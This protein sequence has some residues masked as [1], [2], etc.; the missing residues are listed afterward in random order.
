M[1]TPIRWLLPLSLTTAMA[2][3]PTSP[4]PGPE[5]T[6][7][8][9]PAADAGSDGGMDEDGGPAD[10]GGAV[11]D[12]AGA[13]DDAGRP[14]EDGGNVEADGGGAEDGGVDDDG[15]TPAD[16]GAMPSDSGVVVA[17]YSVTGTATGVDGTAH[18]RIGDDTFVD[19]TA[20]G[21]FTALVDLDDGAAYEVVVDTH[22]EDQFCTLDNGSGTIAGADVDTL[23]LT[24]GV[25]H[26][27]WVEDREY[28][29]DTGALSY[30]S[31]AILDDT[32]TRIGQVN[33]STFG[34]D[35][36][37]LTA[38]DTVN[39]NYTVELDAPGGNRTIRSVSI[40]GLGP[41]GL[42]ATDDDVITEVTETLRDA[43]GR[44]LSV[45]GFNA[46]GTDGDWF[47]PD[48]VVN[49]ATDFFFAFDGEGRP[50]SKHRHWYG[51]DAQ[52]DTADDVINGVHEYLYS[53]DA[54]TGQLLTIDLRIDGLGADGLPHT[55]D[56]IIVEAE[57]VYTDDLGRVRRQV[58]FREPGADDDW[59]TTI[60]NRQ[61]QSGWSTYRQYSYIGDSERLSQSLIVDRGPDQE[62]FTDDDVVTGYFAQIFGRGP[63]AWPTGSMQCSDPGTDGVFFTDDDVFNAGGLRQLDSY[64]EL[65]RLAARWV[66]SGTGQLAGPDGEWFTGDDVVQRVI[67]YAHSDVPLARPR[68]RQEE[69]EHIAPGADGLWLT[70]DDELGYVIWNE[71]APDG[72]VLHRRFADDPGVDGVW[73]TSDDVLLVWNTSQD[74]REYF[75]SDLNPDVVAPGV[76]LLLVTGAV[77]GDGVPFTAD[78]GLLLLELDMYDD[79]GHLLWTTQVDGLDENGTDGLFGTPDDTFSS[80]TRYHRDRNGTEL[81]YTDYAGPGADM[82]WF[83]DDDVRGYEE[84][85][86]VAPGAEPEGG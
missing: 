86:E 65:G 84:I 46:P 76:T 74:T 19:I 78:D 33:S 51:P 22:P 8:P 35:G 82:L 49:S 34:A 69:Q 40:S 15:G 50:T 2:C 32:G 28:D 14:P 23:V 71:T 85:H 54:P 27:R 11:V 66:Y 20:D 4:E 36:Q 52:L 75:Y 62:Y 31:R 73:R 44:Q 57:F 77:G 81:S 30:V 13:P 41:D 56:D 21:T 9:S 39:G 5:P 83:T 72:R 3:A 58:S 80:L 59:T 48:D 25:G 47:T 45:R 70:L 6:P 7:E 26:V 37:P 43:D 63:D 1:N 24:C 17:T 53:V 42:P 61:V 29:E 38:D 64:D 60:D 10:D 55:D 16:G 18:L 12:D 67:S 79:A 68:P